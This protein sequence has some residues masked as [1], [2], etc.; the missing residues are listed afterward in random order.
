MLGEGGGV[1]AMRTDDV[2]VSRNYRARV[3][4]SLE[5]LRLTERA[6][7]RVGKTTDAA[8]LAVAADRALVLFQQQALPM[9]EGGG[10][11]LEVSVY[12]WA[13]VRGFRVTASAYM[14]GAPDQVELVPRASFDEPKIII[15]PGLNEPADAALDFVTACIESLDEVGRGSRT[16]LS[17]RA[18]AIGQR[19]ARERQEA[20]RAVQAATEH[21]KDWDRLRAAEDAAKERYAAWYVDPERYATE[22]PDDD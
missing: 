5:A 12:P 14:A 6:S 8:L 9:A 4:G 17:E 7:Y 18:A 2:I 20:Y 15:E 19:L 13:S 1:V 22:H 3:A 16:A 21:G 11:A 10:Y